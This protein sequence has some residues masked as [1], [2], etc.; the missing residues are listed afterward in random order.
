MQSAK[1]PDY[2]NA[3]AQSILNARSDIA[4]TNS[5]LAD[6]QEAIG[7]NTDAIETLETQVGKVL[8]N[9][10][11]PA[12]CTDG[13]GKHWV[14]VVGTDNSMYMIKYSGGWGGWTQVGGSWSSGLTAY[15]DAHTTAIHVYGISTGGSDLWHFSMPIS[16][17]IWASENLHGNAGSLGQ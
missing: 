13:N 11:N 12:G 8:A 16:T 2:R 14:F 1:E 15:Y 4:D 10:F 3:V 17:G 7:D 6:A 5:T 9:T